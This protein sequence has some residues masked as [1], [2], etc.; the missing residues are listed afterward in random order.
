[1]KTVDE[2][3]VDPMQEMLRLAQ[4]FSTINT[5]GFKESYRSVKDKRL[6]FTS[7]WCH[8]K[9]VW[10]GWDYGSGNTIS[11]HYGRLHAPSENMTM[12]WNG[13]ECQAWHELGL[14]LLFLDGFSASK[15]TEMNYS[16]PLTNKFFEEEIRQK[17]YRRQPEWLMTMHMEVWEH[18]GKRFFELFDLRRPDLWERYRQFLK[19]F[20]DI[21]GRSSFITPSLDKVC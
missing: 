9:F 18:Y 8:I 14:A 19:E 13:E 15:A 6:I 20:Y 3:N 2:R 21:E 16:T 12:I 11:I 17:F 4:N 7:E 5:W 1:M 10:G